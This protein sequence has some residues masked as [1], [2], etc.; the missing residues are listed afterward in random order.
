MMPFVDWLTK[1]IHVAPTVTKVTAEGVAR[2]FFD[3][4][5]RHHCLPRD[6]VSDRDPHFTSLFGKNSQGYWVPHWPCQ[7]QI[8]LPLMD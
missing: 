6:L 4:V 2:L 3:N 1:R 8:M 7:Q 5:F